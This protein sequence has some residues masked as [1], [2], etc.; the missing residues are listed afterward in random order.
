MYTFI[1]NV[2]VYYRPVWYTSDVTCGWHIERKKKKKTWKKIY[3]NVSG[4][5]SWK[6]KFFKNFSYFLFV[7][8]YFSSF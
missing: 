3:Q 1:V 4:S 6:I 8:L 2:H 7:Y 5:S